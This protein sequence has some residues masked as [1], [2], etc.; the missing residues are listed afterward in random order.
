MKEGSGSV[1]LTN[2]SG[3]PTTYGSYGSGSEFATLVRY[4]K[5]IATIKVA[6]SFEKTASIQKLVF[7]AAPKI[8]KFNGTY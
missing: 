3:G 5:V 7:H 2:G 6:D 1:S 8:A 4:C